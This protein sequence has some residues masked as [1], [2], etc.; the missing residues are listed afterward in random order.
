MIER[1]ALDVRAVVEASREA[2]ELQRLDRV[3]RAARKLQCEVREGREAV[4]P[5]SGLIIDL[6]EC[7]NPFSLQVV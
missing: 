4:M 6:A 7:E 2:A 3:R 5:E 1:L